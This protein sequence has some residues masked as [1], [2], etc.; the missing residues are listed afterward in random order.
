MQTLLE[1][2]IRV[3]LPKSAPT[4]CRCVAPPSNLRPVMSSWV[5]Q[6]PPPPAIFVNSCPFP[7]PT[8]IPLAPCSQCNPV[9]ALRLSSAPHYYPFPPHS[10]CT[11]TVYRRSA[12]SVPTTPHSLPGV[13]TV[14]RRSVSSPPLHSPFLLY[15]Q[16][17]PCTGALSPQLPTTPIP[18][19]LPVHTDLHAV[20][21]R[22][23]SSVPHHSPFPPYSQYIPTYVPCT[24]ALS[25]RRPTASHPPGAHIWA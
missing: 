14:Y 5:V 25:P 10:Q 18:S 15:S 11:P 16:C 2:G 17:I 20:Y 21:R 9:Q 7:I 6:V 23:V 12:S 22:S 3:S 1:G 24:G 19:L 13:H 4:V 8:R